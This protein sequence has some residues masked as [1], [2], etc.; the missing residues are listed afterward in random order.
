MEA[1][2]LG[3]KSE[4]QLSAYTT[5]IA[6]QDPSRFCDLHHISGQRQTLNALSKA[7]DRTGVLVDPSRVC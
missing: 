3:G 5:A 4:L 2:R 1:L 6:T 7:K